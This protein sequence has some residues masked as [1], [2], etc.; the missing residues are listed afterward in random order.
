ML[1]GTLASTLAALFDIRLQVGR[2]REERGCQSKRQRGSKRQ[3]ERERQDRASNMNRTDPGHAGRKERQANRDTPGRKKH[4]GDP[5]EQPQQS[6]FRQQLPDNARPPCPKRDSHRDFSP[7]RSGTRQKQIR[8][9]GAGEQEDQANRAQQNKQRGFH[10]P[11]YEL[12]KAL[13]PDCQP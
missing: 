12:P 9:I 3:Q 7:A 5:A 4:A 2:S 10:V 1:A 11:D 8:N 6:A 13:N